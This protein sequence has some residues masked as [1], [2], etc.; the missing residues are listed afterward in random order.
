MMNKETGGIFKIHGENAIREL[1][2]ALIA[3][4]ND[5]SEQ[6]ISLIKRSIGDIIARIDD[7]L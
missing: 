7:L 5:C 2:S 4:Q 6:E 3:L 1:T